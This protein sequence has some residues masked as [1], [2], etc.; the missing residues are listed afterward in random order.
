MKNTLIV[1]PGPTGVGKTAFATGLAERLGCDIISCD[2]RQFYR[3]M[4]IGTAAPGEE[5]LARAKH[6]FVGFLSVTEY[7]SISLFER[8]VLALLP[9]LFPSNPVVIMTGGSML[10]MDAV[11]RGMDDIPDTDPAVRQKYLEMY[12]NEGIEGLRIALK[13]LDPVSYSRIDLHNPRRI[14][15]A[16]EITESSGRPYSS[17]LT[18]PVRQR[19]FRIIKAG[20]TRER[21]EL[22]RRIDMRV[23]R[24]ME[25]GLEQE[26][27]SLI[28]YRGLNALNT[29]GY[30]EMFRWF[31]GEVSREEAVMLIRR[32]TRRYARKQLTWW[33]RDSQINWFDASESEKIISWIEKSLDE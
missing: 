33:N 28:R 15:R 24:M 8:D 4:K 31:D 5:E 25:E 27:A 20:L 2:S 19:D 18:A 1:L 7:Y 6:H 14:L 13:L 3:E 16:L 11:C 12:H 9:S 22:Y 30:R 17:F 29:V 26:A 32:N 10:Y 21:S 23:D